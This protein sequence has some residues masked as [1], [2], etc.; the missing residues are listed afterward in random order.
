MSADDVRQ[1]LAAMN[2]LAGVSAGAYTLLLAPVLLL[3]PLLSVL[4]ASWRVWHKLH[5][6][7]AYQMQKAAKADAVA[8]VRRSSGHEDVLPA[9]WVEGAEDSKDLSGWAVK[10]L[11]DKRYD[12]AVHDGSAARLGK[13]SIIHINEDSPE[14]GTW[15][16]STIDNAFCLDRERYLFRDAT[17]SITQLLYQNDAT[18][19]AAMADGGQQ[20]QTQDVSLTRPGVL[21]D[22]LVPL[23]S[24]EG[25]DGQQVSWSQYQNLKSQKSDQETVRDAKNA[26]WTAAKLDSL[27]G[28]DMLK[29]AL[30]IGGWSALLLFK[31]EIGAFIAGLGGGNA[32]GNAASSAGLGMIHVVGM[33]PGVF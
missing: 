7:S 31:D 32:V 6:W 21:E 18:G 17:V 26:A 4:P 27:E 33:V 29:W 20:V 3:A 14:Q 13:A 2:W 19:G 8:N 9:A 15:A 12:P 24:R 28:K 30:I 10:G 1:K 5:T 25:Y 22:V 23:S 11:G 16:E